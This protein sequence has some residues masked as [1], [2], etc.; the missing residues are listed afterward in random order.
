MESL[1]IVVIDGLSDS[2][3]YVISVKC[4][5]A[6]YYLAIMEPALISTD[7]LRR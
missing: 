4:L 5:A 1:R 7:Y 3:K 2:F 6:S